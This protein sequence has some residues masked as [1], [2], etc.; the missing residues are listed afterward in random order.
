M[1]MFRGDELFLLQRASTGFM[2][3]YYVLPGGHQRAGES[4][5]EA[6]QRE[7]VEET[8]VIDVD[9]VPVCVMPYQAGQH[10]G[11]NFVFEAVSWRGEPRLGEPELFSEKVWAAAGALP[12]PHAMWISDALHCRDEGD[13]FKE[14][15]WHG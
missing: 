3:G 6:A 14:F 13:W 9:L 1:L 4:V 2:D 8:G 11:L 15:L 7:C 10:Q 12:E 5:A